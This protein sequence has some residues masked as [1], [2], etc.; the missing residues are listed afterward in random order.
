MVA[1]MTVATTG[2][3]IFT[4]R[5][6]AADILGPITQ[7]ATMAD[8]MAAAIMAG[9]TMEAAATTVEVVMVAAVTAVAEIITRSP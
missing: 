2:A 8:I 3:T 5:A 1:A 6:L 7:A 9:D 4:G